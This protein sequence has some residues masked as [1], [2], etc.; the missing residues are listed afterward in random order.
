M[1]YGA[2]Q[3]AGDIHLSHH[4]C[5]MD[6][7]FISVV[8]PTGSRHRIDATAIDTH[9]C[10]RVDLPRIDSVT[11]DHCVT[12]SCY[13]CYSYQTGRGGWRSDKGPGSSSRV[14][15]TAWI[16]RFHVEHDTR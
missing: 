1:P 5:I 2:W 3:Q 11:V 13:F 16:G 8:L 12:G 9:L 4:V 6:A 7:G 10:W 15:L 14:I